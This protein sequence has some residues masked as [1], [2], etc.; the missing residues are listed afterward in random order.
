MYLKS[1]TEVILLGY[2]S[3]SPLPASLAEDGLSSNPR[4]D[5]KY[6]TGRRHTIVAIALPVE[7]SLVQTPHAET[8][9]LWSV[10]RD[11]RPFRS[12]VGLPHMTRASRPP[13]N[14]KEAA[15]IGSVDFQKCSCTRGLCHLPGYHLL[16]GGLFNM[17]HAF[18]SV[19]SCN[20]SGQSM[21][22][23]TA[24]PV[25]P[26]ATVVESISKMPVLWRWI[27]HSI[28]HYKENEKPRMKSAE[29]SSQINSLIPSVT[30]RHGTYTSSY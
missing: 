27:G 16:V 18:M 29:L 10:L 6:S 9:R 24:R 3:I 12:S 5:P 8:W 23:R 11:A 15:I 21:P 1:N 26:C 13:L 2:S 20:H 22:V 30:S 7:S 14:I 19:L 4:E 17:T 25:S 28:G